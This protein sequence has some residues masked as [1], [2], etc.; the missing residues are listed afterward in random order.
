[1]YCMAFFSAKQMAIISRILIWSW[2]W[3]RPATMKGQSHRF[4]MSSPSI[5]AGIHEK[6]C[7]GILRMDE[8]SLNKAIGQAPKK[9]ASG[10]DPLCLSIIQSS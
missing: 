8:H 9:T 4:K 6:E 2:D 5:M 1:M 3:S 10:Q 7:I